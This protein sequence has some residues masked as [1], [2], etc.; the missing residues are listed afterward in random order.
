[1]EWLKRDE[2]WARLFA[3]PAPPFAWYITTSFKKHGSFKTRVSFS[4]E[5]YFVQFEELF[6]RFHVDSWRE[7]ADIM[8]L[9][10]S[11]PLEEEAKSQPVSFFTK[12]EILT[13]CFS[14]NR[15]RRFGADE[16]PLLAHQL[17]DSRSAP[18]FGML[19]YALNKTFKGREGVDW[20]QSSQ[21]TQDRRPETTQGTLF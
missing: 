11:V 1:M 19:V 7:I 9:F 14:Q 5:I 12:E 13:G 2:L 8:E 16:F 21:K 20:K 10:Y 18:A 6:V 4:Q 17:A 3:P 15:I